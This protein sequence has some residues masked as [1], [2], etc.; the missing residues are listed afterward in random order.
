MNT[1]NISDYLGGSN[2]ASNSNSYFTGLS[3]G[4]GSGSNIL[5]DYYA[6]RNGSYKKLAKSY[7]ANKGE[8]AQKDTTSESKLLTMAK[9]DAE[10][11]VA[12]LS[13]LMDES[14]WKKKS[15]TSESGEVTEEYDWDKITKNVQAFVDSYNDLLDSADD[16]NS[17]SVLRR[18]LHLTEAV[19]SYA[20][21][22]GKLGITVGKDNKLSL[23][24][25]KLKNA[26]DNAIKSMFIGKNSVADKLVTKISGVSSSASGAMGSYSDSGKYS[27]TV[28]SSSIDTEA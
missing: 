24:T 21:T 3:T 25:D 15:S 13:K 8:D 26:D 16:V 27:G 14:L 1:F 6:I 9:S 5:S 18:T 7:Y 22:L 4:S 19:S 12:E 11:T 10:G 17:N 2:S 20:G 28:T 23:D